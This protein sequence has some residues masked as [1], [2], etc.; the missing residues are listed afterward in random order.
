VRLGRQTLPATARACS[1]FVELQGL[2]AAVQ[3]ATE[4]AVLPSKMWRGVRVYELTCAADFGCGPHR[5][6]VPEY[7]LWSLISLQRMVCPWH[8]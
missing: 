2:A 7:V 3:R 1:A 8:R 5:L 4:I 6:F